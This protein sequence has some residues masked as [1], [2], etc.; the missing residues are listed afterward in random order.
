MESLPHLVFFIDLLNQYTLRS[1]MAAKFKFKG[2]I[3]FVAHKACVMSPISHRRYCFRNKAQ[4]QVARLDPLR[5]QAGLSRTW[6]TRYHSDGS[7][8]W[9]EKSR[10]VIHP[11]EYV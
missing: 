8:V 1:M 11:I 9:R 6:I 4:F 10:K 2:L 7:D 3:A 5:S